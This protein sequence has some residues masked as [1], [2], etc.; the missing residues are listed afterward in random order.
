MDPMKNWKHLLGTMKEYFKKSIE[1]YNK[2]VFVER[3]FGVTFVP[4]D[5]VQN[6]EAWTD[7][8]EVY[9]TLKEK[10]IIRLNAKVNDTEAKIN[11][12]ADGEIKIL[13]GK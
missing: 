13:Y 11:E 6:K 1:R 2:L 10:K 12:T 9:L 7:L 5:L 8:E 3:E 4:K